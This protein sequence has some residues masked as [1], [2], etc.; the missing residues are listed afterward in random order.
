MSGR[1]L[2]V[3]GQT[4]G[5]RPWVSCVAAL[6]DDTPDNAV[7][8]KQSAIPAAATLDSDAQPAHVGQHVS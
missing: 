1:T 5:L 3:T 7:A 6:A 2:L 4:F 8:I